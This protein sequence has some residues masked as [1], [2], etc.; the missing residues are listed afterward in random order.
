MTT[1]DLKHLSRWLPATL[2]AAVVLLA[3]ARLITLSMRDHAAQ[4]RSAAQSTVTRE[5]RLIEAQLQALTDRTRDEARRAARTLA[6]GAGSGPGRGAFWM[7]AGGTVARA[8]DADTAVSRAL[9]NEWAVTAASARAPTGIFGPVRYGSQ[10]IIAA[11]APIEAPQAKAAAASP[12][13]AVGYQSLDALLVRT[14]FG[15]VVKDGYDFGINQSDPLT[16][17]VR[18]LFGSRPCMPSDAVAS[19]IRAPAD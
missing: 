3:G 9:A 5:T 15:Q 16:R 11:Y 12:A 6:Q 2:V 13:W 8:G 18:A 7:S 14:G 1:I 17:R 4:M 10:W 19:A